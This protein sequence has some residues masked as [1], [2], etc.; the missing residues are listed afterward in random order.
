MSMKISKGFLWR[1]AVSCLLI[2]DYFLFTTGNP[3]ITY[4]ILG[5]WFWVALVAAVMIVASYVPS[6]FKGREAKSFFVLLSV[7]GILSV[8]LFAT[9]PYAR[10]LADTRLQT[11]IGS[12]VKDP[13][14]SKTD[15]SN[16][17]RQLMLKVKSQKYS[18]ER[19]TFIPTSRR[20]D[21]LFK[22]ETGENYRLITT[23]SWNGT[24]VISLRRID[25]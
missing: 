14:N 1:T 17:E 18:M 6:S 22:T 7:V 15:V 21:Y 10:E 12:F 16:E 2:F 25:S 4:S 5:G 23:M 8:V 20:M 9:S 13:I 24:P 11:E 19:E 3:S